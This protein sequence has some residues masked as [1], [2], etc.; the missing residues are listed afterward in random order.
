MRDGPTKMSRTPSALFPLAL[1]VLLGAAAGSD[2]AQYRNGL[3]VAYMKARWG[4]ACGTGL[5]ERV[6][7]CSVLGGALGVFVVFA[8]RVVY[9]WFSLPARQTLP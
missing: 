5:Q 4:W 7:I 1:T 2:Y 9:R 3:A 6:V 8:A